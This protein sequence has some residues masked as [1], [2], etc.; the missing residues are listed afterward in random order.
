MM[1]F[2]QNIRGN[3]NTSEI[4]IFNTPLT[5]DLLPNE[6][7]EL[8]DY[9][10]DKDNYIDESFGFTIPDLNEKNKKN[11]IDENYYDF[12]KEDFSYFQD[13]IEILQNDSD[14]VIKRKYRIASRLLQQQYLASFQ[15][16][17]KEFIT[18]VI[19]KHSKETGCSSETSVKLGKL[20][21][22]MYSNCD[23]GIKP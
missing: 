5:F 15:E 2:N 18:S 4:N 20:L 6:I 17:M 10:S 14:N 21:H 8:L 19:T 23:I 22:Y 9:L 1:N 11:G 16:K 12:M 13:I 7:K 3:N